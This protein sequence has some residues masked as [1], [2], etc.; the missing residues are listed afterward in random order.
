MSLTDPTYAHFHLLQEEHSSSLGKRWAVW[1]S[2]THE[3]Q[4]PWLI[5]HCGHSQVEVGEFVFC[6]L[7]LLPTSLLLHPLSLHEPGSSINLCWMTVSKQP[8]VDESF[9]PS[10]KLGPLRGISGA[11]VFSLGHTMRTGFLEAKLNLTGNV[12]VFR[13]Q[14][15]IYWKAFLHVPP[16]VWLIWETCQ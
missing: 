14:F 15:T 1:D 6:F 12:I 10:L 8:K 11:L 9:L 4:K 2:S 5:F 7:L 16:A 13:E 3:H